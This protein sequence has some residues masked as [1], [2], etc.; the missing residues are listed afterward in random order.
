MDATSGYASV[1]LESAYLRTLARRIAGAYQE[2]AHPAAAL[3]TGSAAEGESDRYS[4][5]DLIL[6]Y[7]ALPLEDAVRAAREGCGGSDFRL[8]GQGSEREFA[9]TYV[10]DGVDCQVAHTTITA[11]EDDMA[12]VL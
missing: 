9:E 8:L 3:L 11:W 10:V 5:L 1:T 7:D 2:T 6:Y 12:S 4:D